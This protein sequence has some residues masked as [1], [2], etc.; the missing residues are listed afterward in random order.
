M[1]SKV[2]F[3]MPNFSN[4]LQKALNDSVQEIGFK[5]EQNGKEDAPVD[6]GYYRDHI[7]FDG[8]NKVTA[9]A[10]YSAPLEYGITNPVLITPKSA[11]VLRF[12]IDGK[13][14]FAKWAQQKARKPN[15]IMRNAARKTQ[16][17]VDAIFKK[18]FAKVK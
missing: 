16:K 3:Q 11:K 15:P 18:N 9:H 6:S 14:V 7:S 4:M 13:E 2:T 10:D 1:A 8:K 17:E 12:T 5:V